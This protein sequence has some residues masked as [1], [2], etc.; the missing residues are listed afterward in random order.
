MLQALV[1][2]IPSIR[3]LIPDH[4]AID[5]GFT[6]LAAALIFVLTRRREAPVR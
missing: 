4:W 5:V 2:I 6:V 1:A 3:A